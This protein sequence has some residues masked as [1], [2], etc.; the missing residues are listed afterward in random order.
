MDKRVALIRRLRSAVALVLVALYAAGLVA[1]FASNVQLALILWVVSTL[2]GIGMLY[3]LHTVKKRS[4]GGQGDGEN[5][6]EAEAMRRWLTAQGFDP[7]RIVCETR[8]KNTEENLAF[9]L[10]LIP[11]AARA[12]I[13]VCSSEYHLYRARLLGRRMGCELGAIPAKT[14]L[15]VLRINYFIREGLGALYYHILSR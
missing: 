5:I 13:A 11:D 2:G 4:E 14:T 8:S 7:E 15:P 9:S 12:R 6:T 3:W 1:M 10:A